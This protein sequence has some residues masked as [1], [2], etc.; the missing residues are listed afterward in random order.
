[1]EA[2]LEYAVTKAQ[3][4]SQGKQ[5]R[6]DNYDMMEAESVTVTAGEDDAPINAPS[7][8]DP[9]PNTSKEA[10]R[11]HEMMADA[12]SID[13]TAIEQ[14]AI[15]RIKKTAPGLYKKK[16]LIQHIKRLQER[17]A[18]IQNVVEAVVPVVKGDAQNPA[19]MALPSAANRNL[20]MTTNGRKLTDL[21]VCIFGLDGIGAIAAEML[22]RSG[23]GGLVIIDSGEVTKDDLHR[24]YYQEEQLALPRADAAKLCL[25]NCA[26]QVHVHAMQMDLTQESSAAEAKKLLEGNGLATHFLNGGTVDVVIDSLGEAQRE[27]LRDLCETVGKT[28]VECGVSEEAACAFY[29][30]HTDGAQTEQPFDLPPSENEAAAMMWKT[31]LPST[32]QTIAGLAVQNILKYLMEAGK[33]SSAVRYNTVSMRVDSRD[34]VI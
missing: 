10:F 28:R 3:S 16:D 14:R 21:R 31:L 15:E 33:V 25:N 23:V 24:L 20:R 19:Q 12:L 1:M 27:V 32:Y 30:F 11:Q 7:T 22:A 4:L 9:T 6:K 17:V 34:M 29:I 18:D 2:E 26:P 8:I 5:K 13:A